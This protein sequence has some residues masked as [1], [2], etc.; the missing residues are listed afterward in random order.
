MDKVSRSHDEAQDLAK[1]FR[2]RAKQSFLSDHLSPM[3]SETHVWVNE[4]K[5]TYR[6]SGIDDIRRKDAVDKLD[7]CVTEAEYYKG[8]YTSNTEKSKKD[9]FKTI[10]VAADNL[11]KYVEGERSDTFIDDALRLLQDT[12]VELK[13]K[14]SAARQ[15]EAMLKSRQL[16]LPQSE[17]EK[18]ASQSLMLS[19]IEPLK[20]INV[21]QDPAPLFQQYA[22]GGTNWFKQHHQQQHNVQTYQDITASSPMLDQ[23]KTGDK[24][25]DFIKNEMTRYLEA[26]EGT[27]SS[28][29][30]LDQSEGF[31][32]SQITRD[33]GLLATIST[34]IS[35]NKY[36]CNSSYKV[37]FEVI[38]EYLRGTARACNNP[39]NAIV[40]P[41]KYKRN[42]QVLKQ[43]PDTY[44]ELTSYQCMGKD[45]QQGYFDDLIQ[46]FK[47]KNITS[48]PDQ[49]P[50][51]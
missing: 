49:M 5:A 1:T 16:E 9:S 18:L 30:I 17:S 40:D 29:S 15:K 41:E 36:F 35:K 34:K 37:C 25:A 13:D 3:K 45:F 26:L 6:A 7:R 50:E 4:W 48:F 31:T 42:I 8:L 28:S 21:V 14:V 19:V 27:R 47:D 22:A 44:K 20:E 23:G 43:F 32:R 2:K 12:Y 10:A 24:S 11:R 39:Y 46:H 33:L 51:R 38:S